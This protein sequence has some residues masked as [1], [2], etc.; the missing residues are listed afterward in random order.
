MTAGWAETTP[1]NKAEEKNA[2]AA[3]TEEL[4]PEINQAEI[5]AAPPL[6][7]IDY[8]KI[9]TQSVSLDLRDMDI[10]DVLKFLSLKGQFNIAVSKA[11]A[12]RITLVMKEVTIG[13]ALDI[14]LRANNLAYNRLRNVVYIMT[15][16]EYFNVYGKKFNDLTEVQIINLKYA[17]PS[18]VL[19]ALDSLKS[20]VGK[21]VIDEDTGSVVLI[22]TKENLEKMVN[23][24]REIDKRVETKTYKLQYAL[25]KDVAA[26]L[27]ARLDAKS[28]GMIQADERSNQLIISALPDRMDEVQMLI[29]ELDAATKAVRVDMRILQLT[30]NPKLL[31]DRGINWSNPFGNMPRYLKAM[32][33]VQSF[34]I[35]STDITA[36]TGL[37]SVTYGKQDPELLQ[38][39][40]S[41]LRQVTTTRVI[42]SPR[43]VAV[44]NQE[45]N[46]HI[47]DTIPYVTTTT[48]GSGDT[49]TVSESVNF[50]DV[51]I[52]IKLTPIINDDGYITMKIKP[53][54]SSKTGVVYTPKYKAEIPKINTTSVETNVII[55][56]E[57]TVIIGGLKQIQ[58]S[59]EK[60]GLP[61]LMD[62]PM[63]GQ[64]FRHDSTS[65][66]DTEIVIIVTPHIVSGVYKGESSMNEKTEIH[67]DQDSVTTLSPSMMIK[68]DKTIKTEGDEA[69]NSEA[70]GQ[71]LNRS[72][73][74]EFTK[75]E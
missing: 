10:V 16:E 68:A 25:A 27:K 69:A 67:G 59:S 57:N 35:T 8:D 38:L 36:N 42:A 32:N 40:I 15:A 34:P 74:E 63:L 11:I 20:N 71:E 29:K 23:T 13:D 56:D 70:G 41:A 75:N 3:L 6:K 12:G 64:L 28:V 48:T 43:I 19:A 44:N 33:V 60:K 52:K 4:R 39:E 18:Y 22:D 46:I 2:P 17:K 7:H 66:S 53:E 61:H 24:I 49:A 72:R 31:E 54:I 55:K 30:L 45:A 1:P 26:Q 65:L 50:I 21:I 58:N 14:I 37:G 47:G 5:F 9:F 62:V 73:R 51:G